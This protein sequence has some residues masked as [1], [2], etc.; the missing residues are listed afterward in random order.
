MPAVGSLRFRIMTRKSLL[1]VGLIVLLVAAV[2]VLWHT[3]VLHRKIG[4]AHV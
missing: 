2:A 3:G 1:P 4:R